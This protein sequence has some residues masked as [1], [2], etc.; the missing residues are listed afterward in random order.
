MIIKVKMVISGDVVEVYEYERPIL[1]GKDAVVEKKRKKGD[2]D[3]PEWIR[4]DSGGS[5]G[6]TDRRARLVSLNRARKKIRRLINANV[7]RHP[8]EDGEVF[9]PVF[10]TLTFAENQTDVDEANRAFKRF[11]RRMNGQVY[12]RGRTGLKYVTVIEFQKRGAVHYHCV[13]FNLPYIESSRIAE[14][15]GRGYIKVNAMKKRDGTNCDNVGAYVTKYMQKELDDER[16][17]G[18][19]MYLVSQG[20]HQPEEYAVDLADLEKMRAS[21]DFARVF[22]AQFDTEYQGHVRY[23]QYNFMG[24]EFKPNFRSIVVENSDWDDFE[25]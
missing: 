1:T 25:D 11:I 18:R 9:K 16:L 8:N 12:G 4:G 3:T 19:K 2:Q 22:E 23:Q 5:E 10:M 24:T 6:V 14:L 17:H 7:Y 15:W 20:L 21:I 13:F